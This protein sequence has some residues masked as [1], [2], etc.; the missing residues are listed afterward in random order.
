MAGWGGAISAPTDIPVVVPGGNCSVVGLSGYFL[1]THGTP[2]HGKRVPAELLVQVVVAWLKAWAFARWLGCS[3]S[4][5]IPCWRGWWR[6][7][8]TP[9]L[10]ALLHDVQVSQV[11][12][13]ELFALLS[14]VKAGRSVRPRRSNGCRARLTGSGRAIDPVTKLLLAI[15]VG[16]R[17]LAMAQRL[18]HQVVQVLA[19]GCLPLFLTDGLKDY[20]TALLTHFGHW[21]Q[22]SRRQAR[23]PAPKPRWMPYRSCSMR[24]WSRPY[25]RRRLVRVRHRVIF[26]TW[27][28]SSRCWPHRVA[29]QHR[30]Y[31]ADQLSIRQHVAAVG[32][33]SSRSEGREGG[34][35]AA[36][37]VSGLLQFCLPHTSV[38]VPLAQPLPTNG[39][40]AAKRW[41]PRTP[42]IA[43]GL[44]DRVWTLREVLL[45]RCR[46]GRSQRS[47]RGRLS[48]MIIQDAQKSSVP[49]G[50]GGGLNKTK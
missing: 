29:D 35:P 48:M 44:T 45:F 12:L 18:V 6:R 33:A 41:R 34:A 9:G 5:P 4:I 21:V 10:F 8:T 24:R 15:D 28:G 26:G 2:L 36:R 16:E 11:Q 38:R 40:G 37:P 14:A 50:L 46:R 25:R 3:R 39:A 7:P 1:E 17:N 30:L 49:A 27:P 43:A 13:D 23:G 31:R 20:V 42:A 47:C 32:G 19:P 22:P